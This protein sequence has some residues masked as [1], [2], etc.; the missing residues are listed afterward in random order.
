MSSLSISV[1]VRYRRGVGD[2]GANPFLDASIKISVEFGARPRRLN[3]RD[4][5]RRSNH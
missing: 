1:V 3:V 2:I 5:T 4:K